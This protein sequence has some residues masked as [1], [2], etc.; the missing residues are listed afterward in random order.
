MASGT[1]QRAI[2][3]TVRDVVKQVSAEQRFD[4]EVV[5][6]DSRANHCRHLADNFFK[7]RQ[8]RPTAS[9]VRALSLLLFKVTAARPM[10]TPRKKETR[11]T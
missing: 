7:T 4:A 10:G 5:L 8:M 6:I 3:L 9:D 2:D 11:E 1:D